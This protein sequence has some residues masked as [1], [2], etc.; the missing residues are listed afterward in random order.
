MMKLKLLALSLC[1]SLWSLPQIS[2]ASIEFQG[3]SQ[4]KLPE[5]SLRKLWFDWET[6]YKVLPEPLRIDVRLSEPSNSEWAHTLDQS[7]RLNPK[8]SSQKKDQIVSHELAHVFFNHY[9]PALK[10]DAFIQ[11]SFAYFITQDYRRLFFESDFKNPDVV[12]S[13]KSIDLLKKNIDKKVPAMELAEPLSRVLIERVDKS[14]DNGK[15]LQERFV[16]M[17]SKCRETDF[18]AEKISQEFKFFLLGENQ[19]TAY[20]PSEEGFILIDGIS[21]MPLVQKG[22]LDQKLSPG[23][24]LKPLLLASS[25][26]VQESRFSRKSDSWVCGDEGPSEKW[27]RKWGWKEALI[28][29]CNGFFLDAPSLTEN[30]SKTYRNHLL[31]VIDKSEELPSSISMAHAIGLLPGI[32]LRPYEIALLYKNIYLSH[33]EIIQALDETPFQGT[34]KNYPGSSWFRENKI[35]TKTGTI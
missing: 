21:G 1:A 32:S 26:T 8:I 20:Y 23:S 5:E 17:I 3:V 22:H 12:F 4:V 15:A 28:K 29:S 9:C 31:S 10:G 13:T 34:I 33:P 16:Q 25:P 30:E 18:V 7:I 19:E 6:T 27:Q 35:A 2:F 24:V 11:E 14:P